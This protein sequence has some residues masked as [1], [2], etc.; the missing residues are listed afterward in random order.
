MTVLVVVAI[1][2]LVGV[3]VATVETRRGH[4]RKVWV[5]GPLLGPFSLPIA[6]AARGG[7]RRP[8]PRL[9]KAGGVGRGSRDV[10]VA[11]DGSDASIAAAH[12]AVELLADDLH[13]VTLATV[14]DFDAD[15]PPQSG[16]WSDEVEAHTA[17]A[18]IARDI[19]RQAGVEPS[20]VL[21]F[22]PPPVALAVYAGDAGYD[23][24]VAGRRGRGMA[25]TVLGSCATRLAGNCPV[26]V[27]LVPP[28][29]TVDLT[30]GG[31]DD[32]ATSGERGTSQRGV[33]G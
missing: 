1:W 26:P 12:T 30:D 11:V 32:T 9:L 20:T 22:G 31:H 3:A 14:L 28:E 17:L 16:H 25:K 8:F 4:W 7:E 33:T 27:L 2:L 15:D 21:L 13:T 19:H 18:T 29:L 6:L 10:L 5:L 24:V 23:L